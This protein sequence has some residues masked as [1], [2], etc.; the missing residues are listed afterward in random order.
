MTTGDGVKNVPRSFV[1]HR[2]NTSTPTQQRLHLFDHLCGILAQLLKEPG[3]RVHVGLR[4]VPGTPHD[5]VERDRNEVDALLGQFIKVLAPVISR[6]APRS[7]KARLN[8]SYLSRVD[9]SARL[10]RSRFLDPVERLCRLSRRGHVPQSCTLE[11]RILALMD[12]GLWT[13]GWI[14]KPNILRQQY[15][16]QTDYPLNTHPSSSCF[17]T[18]SFVCNTQYGSQIP[19]PNTTLL[20]I[21]K[22]PPWHKR[23]CD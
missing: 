4:I 2:K 11:R 14:N 17:T 16:N 18:K 15:H 9:P 12:G 19:H 13:R 1:T 20:N 23:H 3:A 5:D 22:H 21:V 6:R 10:C 7:A 8:M